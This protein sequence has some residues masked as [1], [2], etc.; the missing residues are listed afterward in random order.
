MSEGEGAG[1]H[2]HAVPLVRPVRALV[3]A[4]TPRAARHA[5]APQLAPKLPL[6]ARAH[7]LGLVLAPAAVR[8]AVTQLRPGD[9]AGLRGAEEVAG[10]TLG[11]ARQ[12]G[13]LVLGAGPAVRAAVAA[14]GGR[15]AAA[16]QAGELVLAAA[17]E[18]AA[19]L[20][21]GLGAVGEAVAQLVALQ[22]R[23]A[24]AGRGRGVGGL[25]PGSC[26]RAERG[27]LVLLHLPLP[28]T[29]VAVQHEHLP[30]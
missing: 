19:G 1:V 16:G 8:A 27:D 9:T 3:P 7:R 28:H 29:G 24:G 22:P 5:A 4:V 11:L 21:R 26:V 13:H 20:V 10:R 12:A 23:E 18:H 6:R 17:S 2:R 15:H 14:P 25:Q 30:L